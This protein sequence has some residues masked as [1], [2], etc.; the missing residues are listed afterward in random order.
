[1]FVAVALLCLA[2][3]APTTALRAPPWWIKQLVL[4][5]VLGVL[6]LVLFPPEPS[7]LAHRVVVDAGGRPVAFSNGNLAIR[8]V[9]TALK[10]IV[11]VA[12]IPAAYAGAALV[13]PRAVKALAVAFVTGS[14][15]SGLVAFID[16]TRVL[17]IGPYLT[18]LHASVSLGGRAAGFAHHPNFLAAGLVL[19]TPFACWL[20]TSHRRTER[21][22]GA[23]CLVSDLLGVY[24][25]GSR[26]GAVC[27]VGTVVLS[28]ALLPRTRPH[29]LAYLFAAGVATVAIAAVFPSFGL[30]LLRV[31]RL[32]GNPTAAGSDQVR[33]ILATQGVADFRY[34]PVHGIGLQV[35]TQASQVYLQQLASGGLILFLGVS[36]Y[37]LGAA[38]DS[39]RLSR[40]D[41][42]AA[43]ITAAVLGTLALN[44]FEADLTDRFYYVPEAILVA[45]LLSRR[46]TRRAEEPTHNAPQPQSVVRPT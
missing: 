4:V 46:A 30:A 26:G 3:G 10:F 5:L 44:T 38:W 23:A 27:V 15:I 14:S 6:L 28:V 37:M 16:H 42:L 9:G 22:L 35:S 43:A 11:A 1:V 39:F 19:A 33:A 40:F 29:F 34:S 45:M 31:T 32:Y 7:Y 17:S 13:N 41:A 12:G 20:L 21:W 24:G 2:A 18:H 8:N 25:S 36:A